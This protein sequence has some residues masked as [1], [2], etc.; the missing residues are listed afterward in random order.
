MKKIYIYGDVCVCVCFNIKLYHR[1]MLIS[2]ATLAVES[3]FFF[4]FLR[5]YKVPIRYAPNKN[6]KKFISPECGEALKATFTVSVYLCR[7]VSMYARPMFP[8]NSRNH[9]ETD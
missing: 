6:L 7:Y 1:K 9:A 8:T 4:E 5:E 3:T 2:L